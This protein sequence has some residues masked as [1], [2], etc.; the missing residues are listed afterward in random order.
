MID[1]SRNMHQTMTLF[2]CTGTDSYGQL[3][4]AAGVNIPCRWQDVNMVAIDASG[5]EY[6]VQAVAYTNNIVE[7]GDKLAIGASASIDSAKLVKT[8]SNTP[9]LDGRTVLHKASMG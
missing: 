6:I 3:A 5:K 8:I 2:H 4:Y 9:S 7:L 1:Y